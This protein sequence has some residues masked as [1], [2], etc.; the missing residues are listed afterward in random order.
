LEFGDSAVVVFEKA[1]ED[2]IYLSHIPEHVYVDFII[3]S[4]HSID[5]WTY[6]ASYVNGSGLNC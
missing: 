4:M 5:L 1:E 2:G 6:L 3:I